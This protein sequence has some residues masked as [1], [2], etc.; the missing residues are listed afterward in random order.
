MEIR[1]KNISDEYKSKI[2]S[3]LE[4]DGYNEAYIAHFLAN[5]DT[6][7]DPVKYINLKFPDAGLKA[8]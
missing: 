1:L 3:Y 7:P 4:N 6:Q 8:E 2:I 5:A